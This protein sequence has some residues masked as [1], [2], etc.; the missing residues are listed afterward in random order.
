MTVINKAM[1]HVNDVASKLHTLHGS[2]L[3]I[4]TI[5]NPF[6]KH[7]TK[8]IYMITNVRELG[9]YTFELYD[10]VGNVKAEHRFIL[11]EVDK[12]F[13]GKEVKNDFVICNII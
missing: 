11:S 7:G 2:L 9:W 4:E 6:G 12:F 10:I 3:E 5:K 1:D 13:A 8:I